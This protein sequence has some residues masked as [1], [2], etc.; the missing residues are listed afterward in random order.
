MKKQ[1]RYG[2]FETNSSST[3]SMVVCS[4][5]DLERWKSGE[6]LY[7]YGGL[8]EAKIIDDDQIEDYETYDQF[9]ESECEEVGERTYTTKSG[10]VVNIV[11]KH[12][13]DR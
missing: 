1:I 8:I 9:T 13:N 10:E 3:H 5:E 4:N 11:Y 7:D 6:L 12:G 2:V